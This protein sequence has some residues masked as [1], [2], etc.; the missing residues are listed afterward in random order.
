MYHSAFQFLA[1]VTL[2]FSLH[3]TELIWWSSFWSQENSPINFIE[4]WTRPAKFQL[5]GQFLPLFHGLKDQRHTGRCVL[6]AVYLS[7]RRCS[8]SKP[9]PSNGSLHPVVTASKQ[10]K[11][12]AGAQCKKSVWQLCY[13]LPKNSERN[14]CHLKSCLQPLVFFLQGQSNF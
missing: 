5:S 1:G 12:T 7:S 4:Q 3:K 9:R 10:R 6:A 13:V 8:L 14:F 11:M 2:P